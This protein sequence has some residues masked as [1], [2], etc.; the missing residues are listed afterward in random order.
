MGDDRFLFGALGTD[1]TGCAP[2]G[3]APLFLLLQGPGAT[4]R[5]PPIANRQTANRQPPSTTNHCSIL[6]LWS[7]PCLDH[8]AESVPVN[9]RFCWHYDLFSLFFPLGTGI[10]LQR[11]PRP[12]THTPRD[13]PSD[14]MNGDETQFA[15][16]GLFALVIHC[17]RDIWLDF[18]MPVVAC[19]SHCVPCARPIELPRMSLT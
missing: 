17:I 16:F 1:R 10:A 5:Q 13:H 7:C 15:S 4:N 18:L 11:R 14:P 6:F 2:F 3:V 19:T 8:E 12:H 9:V